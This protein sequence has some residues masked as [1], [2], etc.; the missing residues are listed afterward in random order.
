MHR[1]LVV[2]SARPLDAERGF[3]GIYRVV[4]SSTKIPGG[5][6]VCKFQ[7]GEGLGLF[8]RRSYGGNHERVISGTGL[9]GHRAQFSLCIQR[10]ARGCAQKRRGLASDNV[11]GGKR[12]Q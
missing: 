5:S 6:A 9:E 11:A 7:R 12:A 2:A 3:E 4:R 1:L 10:P 8:E